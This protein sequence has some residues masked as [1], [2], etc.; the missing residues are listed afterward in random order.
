MHNAKFLV[1]LFF[2][3]KELAI[4]G[5]DLWQDFKFGAYRFTSW[6]KNLSFINDCNQEDQITNIWLD[7]GL[8]ISSV[9]EIQRWWVLKSKVFGQ[10]STSSKEIV[11]FYEY[12]ELRFVKKCQNCTFKVD[13]LCQK[14]TESFWI[15]FSLMNINLG[16][17]FLIK[18]FFSNFNFWTTL[19]SK[20]MPNFWRTGIPCNHKMQWFPLSML[21]FGQKSCFLGPTIFS[22]TNWH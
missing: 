21:I 18:T 14:S 12:N 4:K 7:L 17:H 19:F 5:S 6:N 8:N 15:F 10:E 11:V 20:I 3:Y 1:I 13:F 16:D 2:E 9:V 22:T